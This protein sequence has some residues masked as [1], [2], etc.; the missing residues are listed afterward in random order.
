MSK[1]IE[2]AHP[3][4]L[5]GRLMLSLESQQAYIA[6]RTT[7]IDL[8]IISIQNRNLLEIAAKL[9]LAINERE[10]TLQQLS[11]EYPKSNTAVFSDILTIDGIRFDGD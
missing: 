9:K 4:V 1:I 3:A 6:N 11:R 8:E 7:P 10:K 2:I 5:C